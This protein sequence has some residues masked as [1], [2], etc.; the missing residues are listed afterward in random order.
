[1]RL[2][3]ITEFASTLLTSSQLRARHPAGLVLLASLWI[4]LLGN[5][6]LWGALIDLPENEPALRL[7][8]RL[9][10]GN[11]T[12]LFL[13]L[14]LVNWSWLLRIGITALLWLA[15]FNSLLLW[16]GGSALDLA[17]FGHVATF[18]THVG[19]LV[20]HLFA[21]RWWQ[22]TLVLGLLAFVPTLWLWNVT[23][24][25]VPFAQRLAQNLLLLLTTACLFIIFWWL[26]R[27]MQELQR[28]LELLTP[29]N[30]V[31]GFF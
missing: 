12:A 11:V 6:P 5:L 29:F 27:P 26:A 15:A 13:L 30:V 22:P 14:T 1:M 28:W 8:L 3:H 2:F 21:L 20:K 9:A 18:E 10:V 16:T 31:R 7:A 23:L 19:R 17:A 4:A 25:R 24:R